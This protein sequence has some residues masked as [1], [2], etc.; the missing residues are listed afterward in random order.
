M[1]GRRGLRVPAA[2]ER[3]SDRGGVQLGDARPHDAEDALV[4]LDEAN[5]SARVGQVDELVREVG[6]PVHVVG[7]GDRR[8]EH[9][10]ALHVMG[11][12]A[13]EQRVEQRALRLPQRRVQVL[14]HHVL[15]RPVAHA[16]GERLGVAHADARVAERPS[17]LVDTEGE[18]SRL[19]RSRLDLPLG[20]NADHRRRER[21][22]LGDDEVLRREPVRPLATV[23]VEDDDLD[24]G[25]ANHLL[26]LAQTLGMDRLDDHE[27]R[28]RLE[29]EPA[30]LGD[31]ELLRVQTVEVAHV[32]VERPRERDD[33][34]R[35]EPPR[36][37]HGREGVEVGVRVAGDD[38]H[39]VKVRPRLACS[40]RSRDGG[41]LRVRRR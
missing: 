34:A 1:D 36:R 11:L 3:G 6:D 40:P 41:F 32:L 37:E 14:G 27:P 17:V 8:D 39:G 22:V 12:E 30:R 35:I 15:T 31:V 33:R 23:V 18:D 29:V 4:H 38:F 7:P 21:P 9:V 2:A 13:R 10:E 19:E 20:E 25:A 28:D 16:P 26:E 5:Q 24:T